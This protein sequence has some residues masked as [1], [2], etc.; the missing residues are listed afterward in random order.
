VIADE[1]KEKII[2]WQEKLKVNEWFFSDLREDLLRDKTNKEV[3]FAIDEVVE[4]IIEQKDTT[5][6]YESFLLLFGIYWK[7]DTTERTEKLRA[8]W[9]ILKN[10]VC[11]FSDIHER[12]FREFE[13]WFGSKWK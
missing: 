5:L 3:F 12:Q 7:L 4:L 2:D 1:F 9:S 11:S 10:H 13:R 8:D 6:V